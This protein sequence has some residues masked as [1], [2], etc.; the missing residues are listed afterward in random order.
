MTHAKS[1]SLITFA[2]LAAAVLIL[3]VVLVTL[4]NIR[5]DERGDNN[6][7]DSPFDPRR[8]RHISFTRQNFEDKYKSEKDVFISIKTSEK[9]H[10]DR[11]EIILKTWYKLAEKEVSDAGVGDKIM[12]A[13]RR[14]P[15]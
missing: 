12:T 15:D 7:R 10:R 1:N 8:R 14:P 9:F 6:N 4:H 3:T 5:P 13:F 2:T 11:L